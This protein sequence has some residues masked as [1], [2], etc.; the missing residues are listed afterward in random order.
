MTQWRERFEK[1][2]KP[3]Q[4]GSAEQTVDHVRTHPLT[5]LSY[6]R[7]VVSDSQ[8]CSR[9]VG[10]M[11]SLLSIYESRQLQLSSTPSKG[12]KSILSD[13][14]VPCTKSLKFVFSVMMS[15]SCKVPN[16]S[17]VSSSNNSHCARISLLN[18]QSN[19][20]FQLPDL[21]LVAYDPLLRHQAAY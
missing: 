17:G 3:K 14:N 11:N 10:I 20:A 5:V 13:A 8:S 15:V 7:H 18:L 1:C 21:L 4:R 19:S 9:R 2:R 12:S 6:I 16:I